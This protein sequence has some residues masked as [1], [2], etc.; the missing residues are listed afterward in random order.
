MRK[1][2]LFLAMTLMVTAKTPLLFY[3]GITMVPAVMEAKQAF[4]KNHGITITV[5]QGGSKDLCT[6]IQATHKGD[7]FLPGKSSYIDQCS[8]AGS[9]R[10]QRIVGYNRMALFVPKGNPKHITG[11]DDLLR[12]DLL[13]TLGNPRTCSIGKAAEE[14]LLRY[15]GGSFLDKVRFGLGL[16]AADSRDMNHILTT[17]QADVGLNWVASLHAVADRG[18]LEILP[19]SDLYAQPQELV[20]GLLDSSTHMD[21]AREFIDYLASA[22]GKSIMHQ[23]GFGDE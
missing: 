18:A 21:L 6:S 3:C 22:Q 19:L 5:I 23:Y 8:E 9:I 10:Y 13:T 11:L 12:H 14:L 1:T 16:F 7:I 20:I 15:G 4:E 17:A 2:V